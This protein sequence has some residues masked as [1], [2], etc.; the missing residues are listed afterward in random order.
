[1][2]TTV[3][4]RRRHAG[5]SM[6][7][8]MWGMLVL[9]VVVALIIPTLGAEAQRKASKRNAQAILFAYS[10][11][12]AARVDW[13]LG[14]VAGVVKAVVDGRKPKD[15]PYAGRLFQAPMKVE[16][17]RQTFPYLGRR[18][19]GELFFDPTGG[20]DSEGL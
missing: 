10:T 7:E 9:C 17:L 1:M 18:P 16:D 11:G 12:V 4:I 6:I 15:G 19:D 14:N 2:K 5:F 13:P 20:Q 3:S 8:L